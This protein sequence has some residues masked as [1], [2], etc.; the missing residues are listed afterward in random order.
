MTMDTYNGDL[1]LVSID[2]D[3]AHWLEHKKD[4]EH[5]G[6]GEQ[7][8][9][10]RS[11]HHSKFTCHHFGQTRAHVKIEMRHLASY[12][13]S[14]CIFPRSVAS[15]LKHFAAGVDGSDS[16]LRPSAAVHNYINMQHDLAMRSP[17][18]HHFEANTHTDVFTYNRWNDTAL[19][20][21]VR[22]MAKML[23]RCI[24]TYGY[25]GV[26]FGEVED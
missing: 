9:C 1:F 14:A 25:S 24:D 26:V 15:R 8:A 21:R 2:N 11:P 19:D 13:Q 22:F 10:N 7:P 4:H 18:A 23:K 5:L 12:L 6:H 3:R 20:M 17:D 16:K